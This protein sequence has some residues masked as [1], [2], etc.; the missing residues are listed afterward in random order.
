MMVTRGSV[1]AGEKVLV[2]GA[3]GGVGT[4]CVLLAKLAGAEVVA[5]ASSDA[6]LQRL[7]EIGADHVINYREQDFKQEIG[8]IYGKPRV[9]GGGG[10]DVVVNF[11][12]GDTWA[13]PGS[14]Y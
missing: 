13:Q 9:L 5:C 11:S 12:G 3:S 2:L 6:K 14:L 10:V 4:G 7:R 1:N 8:R